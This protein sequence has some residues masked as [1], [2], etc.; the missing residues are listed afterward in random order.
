MG[1]KKITKITDDSEVLAKSGKEAYEEKM[2]KKL[3]SKQSSQ[4][5][6]TSEP[7]DITNEDIT[8]VPDD[9]DSIDSQSKPETKTGKP[10]VAKQPKIRGKNYQKVLSLVDKDKTY[11]LN[12]A[13]ALVK[14]LSYSKFDGQIEAHI[15]LNLNPD[16][17]EEQVRTLIK[18]PKLVGK[19]PSILAFTA[20]KEATL[21]AG[22]K[23]AGGDELIEKVGTG[24]IDFDIVIAEPAMMPKIAK[25]GKI[26][27]TKGLMPSP[28]SGT[29]A[30]STSIKVSELL[31]GLTSVKNDLGG[32]IHQVIG[33]IKATDAELVDNFNVLVAGIKKAKPASLK[34]DYIVGVFLSPTMGP[35]VKLDL[36]NIK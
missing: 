21:K 17:S 16:K 6:D 2:L 30:D 35:S 29:I 22:A 28:K 13:V 23:Y 32:T 10:K 19:K 27:G 15:S 1:K 24:W 14:K 5:A 8:A 34:K 33:G 25:L 9:S 20:D 36:A 7:L 31:S 3:D 11:D 4:V 12:D 26:L 18:F